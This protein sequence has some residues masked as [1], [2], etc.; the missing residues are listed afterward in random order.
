M[1]AA[2]S[3]AHHGWDRRYGA[4]K[5]VAVAVV[6]GLPVVADALPVLVHFVAGGV[7]GAALRVHTIA[8][9]VDTVAKLVASES[10]V[11]SLFALAPQVG[12][13]CRVGVQ[14]LFIGLV[15]A[16]AVVA[17]HVPVPVSSYWRFSGTGLP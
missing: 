1:G 6:E 12:L 17:G 13:S 4:A 14:P 3:A 11:V 9:V 15:D 8:V 10:V 5:N 2:V 7:D 16:A